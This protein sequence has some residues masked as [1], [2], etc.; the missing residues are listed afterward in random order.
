[1]ISME[2]LEA[3]V[4]ITLRTLRIPFKK[5]T[6]VKNVSNQFISDDFGVVISV[7]D[8]S[9]YTFVKG[10][11]S[12]AYPDYRYIFVST[13]DSLLDIKD[14]I[15]WALMKGGFMRY[16]RINYPRQFTNL[17]QEGF[18]NKIINER[19]KRWA[20]KPKYKY[21]IEENNKAKQLPTSMI[22]SNDPAFFDYM[23]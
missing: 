21:L 18:G 20:D 1:M 19:L 12:S 7:M 3:E 14:E 13:Q 4:I 8:S 6:V 2:E 22:I 9:D 11:V 10:A 17:I 23:P 16:V 15:V 5:A